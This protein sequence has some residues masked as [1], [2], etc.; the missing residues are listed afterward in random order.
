MSA[1]RMNVSG[2]VETAP[3]KVA[4]VGNPNTGKSTLFNV[5]SGGKARI[6]NYPGVTVEKKTVTVE[7]QDVMLMLWDLYGEDE[8]QHV[9]ESY[10]RGSSGYVLVMDGTR[11]ATLETARLLQQTVVRTVGPLPFVAMIN[12]SDLR[13]EW[14]IDQPVIEQLRD[15][16]WPIFFGSAKLGEG[17]DELFGRLAAM[18]LSPAP[19]SRACL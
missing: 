7:R 2:S 12:K 1:T 3:L 15:Q 13:S 8:F 9:R 18:L 19:P 11:K 5:L 17:V 4:M 6:G 16:G 14:E 10:L